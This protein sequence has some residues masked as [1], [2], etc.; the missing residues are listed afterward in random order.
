VSVKVK[1]TDR[2]YRD[3]LQSIRSMSNVQVVVGVK[4]DGGDPDIADIGFWN[5]FG[6]D[7]GHVPERSFLRS[8]LDENRTKYAG[9][10]ATAAKKVLR[11]ASIRNAYGLVGRRIVFDVQRR[12]SS[13]IDPP[14]APSTIARKGSTVPLVDSGAL[15]SAVDFEVIP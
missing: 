2:G 3:L 15:R 13:R 12:I 5:E 8:T 9:L 4:S 7:D 1:D 10:M 6:T 11:G 14:N